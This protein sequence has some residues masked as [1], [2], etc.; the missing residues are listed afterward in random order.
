[1]VRRKHMPGCACCEPDNGTVDPPDCDNCDFSSRLYVD[2]AI[3]TLA[4]TSGSPACSNCGAIGGTYRINA[5]GI[6]TLDGYFQGNKI[7]S[8]S[9]WCPEFLCTTYGAGTWTKI[10]LGYTLS[11]TLLCYDDA[12]TQKVDT[13]L[14]LQYGMT[15]QKSPYTCPVAWFEPTGNP[16]KSWQHRI[17]WSSTQLATVCGSSSYTVPQTFN[18]ASSA[19]GCNSTADATIYL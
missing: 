12:G 14:V 17:V 15:C 10:G 8:L 2:V 7:A 3:P 11:L 1:M 13:N 18:V 5:S 6:S 4:D 16:C 9:D 19:N